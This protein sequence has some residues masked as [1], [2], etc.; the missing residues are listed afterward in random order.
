MSIGLVQ[1]KDG[2]IF[3]KSEVFCAAQFSANQFFFFERKKLIADFSKF[4]IS[5]R[6]F[7]FFI[8]KC[9]VHPDIRPTPYQKK[10]RVFSRVFENGPQKFIP[11]Q[12]KLEFFFS[13]FQKLEFFRAT[14]RKKKS[15]LNSSFFSSPHSSAPP[16]ST[17]AYYT[18]FFLTTSH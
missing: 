13:S 3:S 6:N 9:R 16:Q 18:T 15:R 4:A 17:R 14:S 2:C 5:L 11:Y 7:L 12:K 8:K 10:T 1:K